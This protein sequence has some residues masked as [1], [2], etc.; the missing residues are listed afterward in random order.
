MNI[1]LQPLDNR[2]RSEITL[3]IHRAAFDSAFADGVVNFIDRD[4][5]PL[6]WRHMDLNLVSARR[7]VFDQTEFGRQ[8]IAYTLIFKRVLVGGIWVPKFMV[9]LRNKLNNEVRLAAALS[10]GAGGHVE[11]KTDKRYYMVRE[12]VGDGFIETEEVDVEQTMYANYLREIGE[13]IRLIGGPAMGGLPEPKILGI[14]ADSKPEKGYVGNSHL[15]FIYAFEVHEDTDFDMVEPLNDRIGWFTPGELMKGIE[16]QPDFE[17][18]SKLIIQQIGRVAALVCDWPTLELS[19][20]AFE[21]L[22][23]L[24]ES[25]ASPT[26]ALVEL[27]SR[28]PVFGE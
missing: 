18:W 11:D 25:N 26:P 8:F 1:R 10:L 6:M 15:G 21:E 2:K 5:L 24:S 19:D 17:P 22:Q 27:M 23:R 3:G 13:E 16:G 9:Y 12:E 14:V 7:S 4:Q 20:A 28:R